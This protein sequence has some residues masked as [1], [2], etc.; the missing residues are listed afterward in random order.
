MKAPIRIH[1]FWTGVQFSSC[2]VN[3]SETYGPNLLFLVNERL[4]ADS[5]LPCRD[6]A[7]DDGLELAG[8]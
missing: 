8:C 4:P 7:P 2:A 1:T 5:W 3:K 6:D